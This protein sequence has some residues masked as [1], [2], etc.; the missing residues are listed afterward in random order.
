MIGV[1][2]GDGHHYNS[3]S[4]LPPPSDMI[5]M[6]LVVPKM[7][8]WAGG[9]TLLGLGD[10]VLPGLMVTYALRIDIL[11]RGTWMGGYF[12]TEVVGYG[13]GLAMAIFAS[14]S[15]PLWWGLGWV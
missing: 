10:V 11:R 1:A 5:P 7:H 9:V 14:V 6:L 4:P 12:L 2:T 13:V 3:S 15:V 8:D